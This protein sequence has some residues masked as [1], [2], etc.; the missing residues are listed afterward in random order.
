M[1]VET[2]RYYEER[3][4]LPK[5]RRSASG[6]RAYDEGAITRVRF[7]KKVQELGF[8]LKDAK[9]L[10]DLSVRPGSSCARVKAL[11]ESKISDIDE[12]IADLQTMRRSLAGLV[13]SCNEGKQTCGFLDALSQRIAS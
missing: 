8:T 11:A 9:A 2:L 3:G 5:P 12:K 7:V 6:Y 4:L 13:A 1:N 10:L